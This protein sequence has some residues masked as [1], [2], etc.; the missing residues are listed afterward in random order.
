METITRL[1]LCLIYCFVQFLPLSSPTVTLTFSPERLMFLFTLASYVPAFIISVKSQV[2][3]IKMVNF[4]VICYVLR[5]CF[6]LMCIRHIRHLILYKTFHHCHQHNRQFN[7]LLWLVAY[8]FIC[9]SNVNY[10]YN[11]FWILTV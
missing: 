4:G 7:I 3:A 5:F 2:F 6:R 11:F 10:M 8:L 9:L 1:F